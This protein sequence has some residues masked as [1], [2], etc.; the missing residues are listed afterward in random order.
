M[1]WKPGMKV[2][3]I[4]GERIFTLIDYYGDGFW[5]ARYPGG[6]LGTCTLHE[7]RYELVQESP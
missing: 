6:G 3:R 2:R 4:G 5:Q 1:L 7:G